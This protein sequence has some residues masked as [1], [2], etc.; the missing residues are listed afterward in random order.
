MNNSRLDPATD[1]CVNLAPGCIDHIRNSLW[2]V[3][4]TL[5]LLV[6]LSV[7]LFLAKV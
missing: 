1:A 7:F 3:G 5:A 6:I 4:S 2:A